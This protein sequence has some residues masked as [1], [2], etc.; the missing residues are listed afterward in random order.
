MRSL[1]QRLVLAAAVLVVTGAVALP[2]LLARADLS[3]LSEAPAPPDTAAGQDLVDQAK[4]VL[5]AVVVKGR[6]AKSGYDRDLFGDGWAVQSGCDMR[7][8]LLAR[9][10]V[11]VAYRP[12]TQ[13]C[14]VESGTLADP[15]TG[16]TFAFQKGNTTSSLVQIDHLV[17]LAL[18]WQQGAQGWSEDRREAFANDP[19]N[20]QATDGA[21]NQQK[22]ASGPGSWL[23]PN[24]GYRVRV[25]RS[26]RPGRRRLRAQHEPRVTMSRSAGCSTSDAERPEHPDLMKFERGRTC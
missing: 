18:A 7:N 16:D 20:L 2:Q 15:Y 17:P 25:R 8:R 4:Q 26:L 1:R 23:P 12:G 22:G 21:T 5:P 13:D 3:S 6:A 11:D 10:L 24:K 14:V 9:D 19:A